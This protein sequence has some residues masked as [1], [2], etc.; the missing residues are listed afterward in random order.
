MISGRLSCKALAALLGS[1][2]LSTALAAASHNNKAD[3]PALLQFAEQY[4]EQTNAPKQPSPPPRST[5]SGG[6][7]A[8]SGTKKTSLDKPTRPRS[9]YWQI[10]D[11]EIQRQSREITQLKAQIA[12][13]QQRPATTAIT[14]PTL[15]FAALGK[16]AQGL[17]Q[18]LAITPTE[19]QAK[20]N[21]TQLQ[22]QW[23]RDRA[24]LQQQLS[25]AKTDNQALSAATNS[26]ENLLIEAKNQAVAL[27]EKQEEMSA[28]RQLMQAELDNT[29]K[30]LANARAD[31]ASLQARSPRLITGDTL[32]TTQPREDY[33][34]GVSLGEEI[35]QMQEERRR[36]G[37]ASDKQMIL[38]GIADSF[39]GKRMLADDELNKVLAAAE[40]KVVGAR[41]KISAA[42]R[43][44]GAAYASEFKKDKRV[45]QAPSGF[46]YRIDYAGDMS[47]PNTASVDVVVKETLTDGTVIQDMETNGATLSQ[48]VAD[49]PPLFKEAISLLKNH[50]S[51]TLVVPPE[52]AYGDKGY[53][54]KVPPNATM[55]YTLRI[56]EM[57]PESQAKKHEGS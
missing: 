53:P 11:K 13:L 25:K 12:H 44:K 14:A 3:I 48:P 7:P 21:I 18:A 24:T 51:M 39:A 30:E 46:W 16:L 5:Y 49:F 50:G 37:V 42:Q 4:H 31:S 23:D 40:K 38:A 45:R 33:A 1:L 54:P 47:I 8:T 6:Q 26:Q 34:A 36:W 28:Q 55:I 52:L 43:Q 29:I 41:E 35:L 15:E 20:A 57:Y 19:L 22:Q 9:E 32:K 27:R 2:L 10:K 17:R 56:A